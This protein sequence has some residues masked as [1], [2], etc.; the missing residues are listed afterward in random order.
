MCDCR[1]SAHLVCKH[2]KARKQNPSKE[3]RERGRCTIAAFPA[4]P[5]AIP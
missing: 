3:A 1:M 5:S 2:P 4:I